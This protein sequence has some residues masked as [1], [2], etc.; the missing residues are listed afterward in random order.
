[1][2]EPLMNFLPRDNMPTLL[3]AGQTPMVRGD[4]NI[5]EL[6][7]APAGQTRYA[8]FPR[9]WPRALNGTGLGLVLKCWCDA[10]GDV[11]VGLAIERHQHGVT[12]LTALTNFQPEVA[13]TLL[14][15]VGGFQR[16]VTWS[17]THAQTGSVAVA[18]TFR[19]RLRITANA[20]AVLFMGLQLS[21]GT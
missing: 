17:L 10:A 15:P 18:E 8:W 20:G 21:N 4:R 19:A 13:A 7:Y 6:I 12:D 2:G 11:G 14:S 16:S 9:M 5:G 1:M 3:F